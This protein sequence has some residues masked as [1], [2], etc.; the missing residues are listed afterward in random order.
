[1]NEFLKLT[2]NYWKQII[3]ITCVTI[4][5]TVA[6]RASAGNEQ[7][8]GTTFITIG[9]EENDASTTSTTSSIYENVQA[10]DHFSESVQ[11]W[12]KN[13]SLLKT[14]EDK[15]GKKID[16]NAKKQEK[17]NVVITYTDTKKDNLEK[18]DKILKE[19][20]EKN[21]E[22]YN[23]AT[24]TRFHLALYNTVIEESTKSYVLYIVLGIIGGIFLGFSTTAM[25]QKIKQELKHL[26]K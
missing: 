24:G 20:L 4:I 2:I 7:Y 26:A 11:G 6:F 10:A 16:I 1:M 8:T 12:F 17:Q 9:V 25:Y 22:E 5:A 19:Q 18:T 15:T 23:S 13:P 14:I 21:I 3:I